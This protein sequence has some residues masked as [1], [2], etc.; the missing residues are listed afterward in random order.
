VP[1]INVIDPVIDF[2]EDKKELN[3]VGVI[4]TKATINSNVYEQKLQDRRPDIKVVSIVTSL[5]AAMIEEGFI[6]CNISKN[7][8]NA[9]LSNSNLERIQA[10]I[11]GCTHYP[12]ISREIQEYYNNSIE[13]IDSASVVADYVN[14]ILSK[15][16]ILNSKTESP[17]YQFYVSDYTPF[18]EN[19][20]QIFFK[21]KVKLELCSIWE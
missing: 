3:N 8:I 6:N 18:F 4:G 19:I 16:E 12:I 15:N 11:L 10:L 13:V 17:G 14:G 21:E 7:V 20:T 5:F 9:Y 1:I 2:I